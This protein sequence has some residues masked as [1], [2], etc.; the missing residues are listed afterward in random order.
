MA[1]SRVKA[2]ATALLRAHQS[3]GL[4]VQRLAFSTEATD[5]AA[6]ALRMVTSPRW[7]SKIPPTLTVYVS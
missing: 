1:I 4:G 2:A 6:A 7:S 3:S 5:A